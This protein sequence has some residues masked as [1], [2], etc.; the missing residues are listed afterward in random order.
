LPIDASDLGRGIESLFPSLGNP[1]RF[2]FQG[3]RSRAMDLPLN[4]RT[5]QML[6][7]RVF[8]ELDAKAVFPP[9]SP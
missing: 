6:A 1:S 2:A 3:K 7:G 9:I 5:M 4:P 8:N